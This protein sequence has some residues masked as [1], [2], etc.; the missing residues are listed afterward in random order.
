MFHPPPK[1]LSLGVS[2]ARIAES[3][4]PTGTSALELSPPSTGIHTSLDGLPTLPPPLRPTTDKPP[5]TSRS[6]AQPSPQP[7]QRPSLPQPALTR[8]RNPFPLA[9]PRSA[10]GLSVPRRNV[11]NTSAQTHML[12]NSSLT[13]YAVHPATNGSASAPTQRT[14][15][16]RGMPTERAASRARGT[17]FIVLLVTTHTKFSAAPRCQLVARETQHLISWLP[18]Q[19]SASLAAN[20]SSVRHATAGYPLGL[21]VRLRKHGHSILR[22]AGRLLQ[23]HRLPPPP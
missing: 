6:P 20:V 16:S 23:Q 13:V 11:F 10:G 7:H 8:P 1:T 22:S 5:N 2:P 18:I 15:L 4:S 14:V 9:H 12:P 19:T 21:R 17:S 3:P